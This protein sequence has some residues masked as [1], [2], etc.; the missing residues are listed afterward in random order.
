MSVAVSGNYYG[1][2]SGTEAYS[3]KFIPEIWS[4]KL[5][6][7]FYQTTVLSEITNN[8]WEG[9]I[10][11]MGDKVEIRTIP[12]ITINSYSKG[13]TLSSQV[14]T[15]DV[16]ELNIDQGKYFQVVVDDVDDV[17]SDIKLM[18]VFTNDASQQMKISVDT[19][20]LAGIK[21]AA[22]AANKGTAAGALSGSINLGIATDAAAAGDQ[23][24]AVKLTKTNVID[25][26]IDM[27]QVLD[28]QNAPE[29][30][31][32]LVIPA[33]AA[34]LIKTSDLK[35]ASITGDSQ[36]PLRNG[37]LGMIDRF[38]LYVSNLLPSNTGIDGEGD[39]TSVKA[40]V[41]YAGT[42]DAV[43]FA[44]QITKM[45]TL[46]SQSTF[47]NIVRGLNVFGYKVIKPE[48]LVEG[49]FYKG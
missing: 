35:D 42:R 23:R 48:A 32:W 8:D 37:R 3:G 9:E 10:K 13:Q 38:T 41:F 6:V 36:T 27:G 17:Q 43:T 26:I 44:S 29:D 40:F 30:G 1:A 14:P 19:D 21:N 39:D 49:F 16:I 11:D 5:Q 18:D 22:A 24:T 45:E 47:G 33:W 34:S 12:T 28:E 31:R 4:G 25:K 46:R 20:V 2:G 7:K 15:N